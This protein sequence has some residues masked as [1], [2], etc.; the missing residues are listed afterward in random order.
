MDTSRSDL[1]L[2]KSRA[3]LLDDPT[4]RAGELGRALG[5]LID[6]VLRTQLAA[7][8]AENVSVVA[9]GSYARYELCPG[10]DL[11]VM[12]V[13][14]GRRDI[15]EVADS[16]WYPLW[17]AGFV[18]GHSV[19]TPKEALALA[20][21]DLD[22]LTALLDAR[23]VSGELEVEA[24]DLIDRARGRARK[25]REPL[26]AKLR[27]AA[28]IR[29]LRPGAIAEMLEPNLKDGAGGLRDVQAFGW[30]GWA[31]GKPGGV[32]TLLDQA[33]LEPEDVELLNAA[34]TELLDIRVALH[35][36]TGGRSDVLA[37]QDQD[38][39][40]EAL[41]ATDADTLV[42]G[43][44]DV[45]RHVAWIAADIWDRLG[46]PSTRS[47]NRAANS[48]RALPDGVLISDRRV[49]IAPDA[50][51][52]GAL[53]LKAA[54]IAATEVTPLSRQSL[55]RFA[56]VAPPAWTMEDRDEF[57]ALLRTGSNAVVV[58]DALDN[59]GAIESILP[60][61]GHVRSLPQ[62]NAYH[63]F[64]VDRHLLETVAEAVALLDGA[65]DQS[66]GDQQ[67]GPAAKCERPDLL[68]LGSLLH[69]IGKGLPGDHS[70]LGAQTAVTVAERIGVDQTGT[71]ILQWLVSEHLLMA[72]TATR[73]DLSD[74][75][76][77]ARFAARVVSPE[78]LR[79]LTL[80]TI[81]DSKATGPAAWNATKASL[82][83][84]LFDRTLDYLYGDGKG[85]TRWGSHLAPARDVPA[86]VGVEWEHL[87]DGLVRCRVVARDRPGFLAAVAGALTLE[88]FDIVSASGRPTDDGRAVE[89]FT[90]SDL[91]SR[92][93]DE[94]GQDR[95]S[96]N[97][98]DAL[99]VGTDLGP[100][101][102]AWISRYGTKRRVSSDVRVEIALDASDEATVVEV[103]APDGVGLLARVAKVFAD[104]GLD[105]SVVKVA[106]TGTMA[107][108]I[109]YVRDAAGKVT[110]E[111]K[112]ERLRNSLLATL[113]S[114]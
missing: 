76:T 66:A 59:A 58:F 81:A 37:L 107:V 97:I 72:D 110:D 3:I 69:D 90:G 17:N 106:T 5:K 7:V 56:N 78:R 15:S 62:R 51:I 71:E 92:L 105:V 41:G 22:T 35:R 77:V 95:A 96:A 94:G 52:S 101:L 29:R 80:L 30:A 20:D 91:F 112:L 89:M 12:L 19:R 109:F 82:V 9:L 46:A 104:Q 27:D 40:A 1:T 45:T 23:V 42:R 65:A 31:L 100:R 111:M 55:A 60:E 2:T 57:I 63:R 36:V 6:D 61:W 73:R 113:T 98:L 86:G 26:I 18:L 93:G 99:E 39:V 14:K 21:K 68:L 25:M 28:V 11:D 24:T 34:R 70:V 64:T 44:S 75:A 10:S 48:R 67:A 103:F 50:E 54:K 33:Y 74:P 102:D 49:V 87:D 4:L 83:S 13:H 32:Q 16:L 53:L 79:L 38:A 108:D 114:N 85:G 8:G 84:E 88:G 43:L 47:S